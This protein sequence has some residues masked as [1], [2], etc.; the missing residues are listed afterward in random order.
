MFQYPLIQ[1]IGR[2]IYRV[3]IAD[4]W[5]VDIGDCAARSGFD[6]NVVYRFGRRIQDPKLVA[7]ATSGVTREALVRATSSTDL[8]RALSTLFDL[9]EMVARAD[10][11]PPFVRDV[12]LG[13][14][15]MQMMVARD[16]EGSAQGFLV[17][18]WGGHNAQSHNHNDVGN[19]IVFAD[20]HPVLVDLGAPTYTAKTFSARRYEIPAMQSSWHNLPTINGTTQS[21]GLAFAARDVHYEATDASAVVRFD[22]APAWPADAGVLSWRRT[23]RLDR[24][25]EVRLEEA[26]EL[27]KLEPGAMLNL[28]AAAAP[29][30]VS[31]GI[32]EIPLRVPSGQSARS[33]ALMFDPG[34]LQ[35]QI[36]PFAVDDQ[37]L[38]RVWGNQLHR[39]QIS[40]KLPQLRDTWTLRLRL[41]TP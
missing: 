29:K 22:I 25:Q 30:E 16:R 39:I 11:Q 27:T 36:E 32:L 17:A 19:F 7:L 2:F 12:W 33:V 41:D 31:D 20:G 9:E 34:K 14:E 40:A 28:I 8:G 38:A 1:E 15:D 18:A 23:V 4:D 13:S 35:A 26:F 37:R 6:R 3:H 5:V 10:A 24:G 21:A